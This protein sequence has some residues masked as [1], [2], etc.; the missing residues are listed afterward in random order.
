MIELAVVIG[1]RCRDGSVE[2]ALE[3]VFGYTI[4]NDV[5]ARTADWGISEVVDGRNDFHGG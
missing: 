2:E 4:A 5:S 1:R 3:N